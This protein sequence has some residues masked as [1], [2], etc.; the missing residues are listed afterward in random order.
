MTDELMK[1]PEVMKLLRVSRGYVY[2][3]AADGRLPCIRLPGKD[4]K[5]GPL[6]FE[7]K[8]I[9]EAVERARLLWQPGDSSADAL[10]RAS[11]G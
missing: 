11:E 5:P 4:G 9:D 3:A 1:P 7:R 6:R 10:R 2:S 8:A